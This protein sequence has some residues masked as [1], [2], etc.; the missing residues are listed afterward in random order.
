MLTREQL[1]AKWE[2][3]FGQKA[4]PQ[5]LLDAAILRPREITK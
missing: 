4:G 5:G 3:V 2:E 1:E